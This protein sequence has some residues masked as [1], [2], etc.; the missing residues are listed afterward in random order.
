MA[1]GSNSWQHS[2]SKKHK[3]SHFEIKI[4][5]NLK[6]LPIFFISFNENVVKL[7]ILFIACMAYIL[8]KMYWRA[9]EKKSTFFKV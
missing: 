6:I 1:V 9:E 3:Q 8:S 7:N 5:H 4:F 2:D